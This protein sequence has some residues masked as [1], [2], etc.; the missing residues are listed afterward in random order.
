MEIK[1][2]ITTDIYF[3]KAFSSL[4]SKVL[5][6]GY[7]VGVLCD[8][9]VQVNN[10]DKLLWQTEQL[11]FIP[12]DVAGGNKSQEQPILISD[13]I[14]KMDNSPNVVFCISSDEKKYDKVKSFDK[15]CF[16]YRTRK[17]SENI[18]KKMIAENI[19]YSIIERKNNKWVA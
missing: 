11:S 6:Q 5:S 15:V 17:E 13:D 16:L 18:E 3:A 12:H 14:S 1:L 9:K 8:D 7:R 10:I 2:Y 19:K 4:C